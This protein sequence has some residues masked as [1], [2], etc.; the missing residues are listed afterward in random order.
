MVVERRSA[1]RRPANSSCQLR[2]LVM[3]NRKHRCNIAYRRG[4]LLGLAVSSLLRAPSSI[5]ATLP[6]GFSETLIAGD[7][8]SP[9]AMAFAP[10]GRLF[11]CQQTGELRVIKKGALL[12]DSFVTVNTDSTG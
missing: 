11:V 1:R 3:K 6:A 12:P 2:P 5:S 10:D 9:T 7:M 8:P 4:V